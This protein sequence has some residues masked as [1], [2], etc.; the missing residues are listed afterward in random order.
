MAKIPEILK[1][2][3]NRGSETNL[4]YDGSLMPTEAF[5]I[6][7]EASV[8]VLVDVRTRAEMD[9]VGFVPGAIHIEWQ[10]YPACQRNPDFIDM[11]R[12]S[13]P[14][15]SLLLFL[16]RSGARSHAAA[17]AAAA[18]GFTG[19][20]NI[21]QGFEGERDAQGHRNC[22]GGWRAAGLPWKQN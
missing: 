14:E 9:W 8:A 7:N 11:L 5:E 4:S 20:Y 1:I 3:Q 21:L 18:A 6:L 22:I 12:Q 17:A 13:V 16:C 15:D 10:D 2:A 19:C